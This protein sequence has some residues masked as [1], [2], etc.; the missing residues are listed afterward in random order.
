MEHFDR[1]E[2]EANGHTPHHL[3]AEQKAERA[4]RVRDIITRE[5]LEELEPGQ[6]PIYTHYVGV[7]DILNNFWF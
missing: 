2:H 7:H 1:D 5:N 3:F 6:A 4:R